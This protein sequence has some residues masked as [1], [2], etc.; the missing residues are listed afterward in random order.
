[1]PAR[2][3]SLACTF[4]FVGSLVVLGPI[5]TLDLF[6]KNSCSVLNCLPNWYLI[7]W[8]TYKLL[9]SYF[10]VPQNDILPEFFSGFNS[11]INL[12]K[13][14]QATPATQLPFVH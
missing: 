2:R 4:Q 3:F 9:W 10:R 13:S 14:S 5:K 7:K 6:K 11:I 12:I 1:M 8:C